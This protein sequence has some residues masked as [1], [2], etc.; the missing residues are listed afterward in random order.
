MVK[1]RKR[2]RTITGEIVPPGSRGPNPLNPYSRMTPKERWKGIIDECARIF[3][4]ITMKKV[5][6]SLESI[7]DQIDY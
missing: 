7:K 3:S 2:I 1:R 5:K 6:S 4:E